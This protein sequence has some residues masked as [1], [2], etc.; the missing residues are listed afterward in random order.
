[1]LRS[2][3]KVRP[4][5]YLSVPTRFPW[6]QRKS[7]IEQIVTVEAANSTAFTELLFGFSVSAAFI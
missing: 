2:V 3:D 5:S 6:S 7:K 4:T 1:M